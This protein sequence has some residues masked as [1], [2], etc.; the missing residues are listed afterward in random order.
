MPATS[1]KMCWV[2]TG[3][4]DLLMKKSG[5]CY[6]V[7]AGGHVDGHLCIKNAKRPWGEALQDWVSE[8]RS[9]PAFVICSRRPFWR[10][11]WAPRDRAHSSLGLWQAVLCTGYC[12]SCRNTVS[13]TDCFMFSALGFTK[14]FLWFLVAGQRTFLWGKV[15]QEIE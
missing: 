14:T 11:E 12:R 4:I 2:L 10:N 7:E 15:V 5:C 8:P 3:M 1:A 9:S 13:G 6:S